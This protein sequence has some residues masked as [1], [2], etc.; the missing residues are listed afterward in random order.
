MLRQN[1]GLISF[2]GEP[3]GSQ[4]YANALQVSLC[5][6]NEH[7]GRARLVSLKPEKGLVGNPLLPIPP[8]T[9]RRG[10]CPRKPLSPSWTAHGGA[11]TG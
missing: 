2:K 4:S 10:P 9:L 11:W 7:N 6:S 1:I 8:C 3:Y 5:T